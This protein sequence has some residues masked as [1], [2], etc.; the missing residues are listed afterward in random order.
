MNISQRLSRR[1]WSSHS[2]HAGTITVA[3]GDI[4]SPVVDTTSSSCQTRN[5]SF[6]TP[7]PSTYVAL[8]PLNGFTSRPTPHPLD[9]VVGPGR[10]RYLEG[11]YNRTRTTFC[12]KPHQARARRP[13]GSGDRTQ[14]GGGGRA[15]GA[16]IG[17]IFDPDRRGRGSGI[18]GAV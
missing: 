1:R 7:N 4:S 16:E 10:P 3:R 2:A 17:R 13:C 12:Q 9:S 11:N 15:P 6:V 14:G 8:Y 5:I 18:N